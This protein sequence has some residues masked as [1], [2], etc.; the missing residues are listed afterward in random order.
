[1]YIVD[2]NLHRL[3]RPRKGDISITLSTP[4]EV[5]WHAGKERESFE[6][7]FF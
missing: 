1:M 5:H 7:L 3:G 6:T 2:V 4:R